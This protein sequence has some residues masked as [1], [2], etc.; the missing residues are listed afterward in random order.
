M[1]DDRMNALTASSSL[2][3]VR[4]GARRRN[5]EPCRKWPLAGTN[6]C[7]LHGGASP[8]AQARAR[9]RIIAATDVAAGRL[10]EFMN[11]KKV[12]WAVRLAAAR[13]LLDRGGVTAKT[14]VEVEAPWQ[15]IIEG[16][17]AEVGDALPEAP[18]PVGS[19]REDLDPEEA[20]YLDAE[21][22]EREDPKPTPAVIPAEAPVVPYTGP[23]LPP[24]YARDLIAAEE[25]TRWSR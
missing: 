8:Q 19:R 18:R 20:D 13:D 16:I 7:R 22:V 23:A 6:R 24:K 11:D 1:S 10:I 2:E 3:P 12:P 4:C 14:V 5:G 25:D 9:E 15:E 21:I 17:V